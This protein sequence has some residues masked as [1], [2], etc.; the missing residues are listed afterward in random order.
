MA[1]TAIVDPAVHRTPGNRVVLH[2]DAVEQ[3]RDLA[4]GKAPVADGAG[5]AGGRRVVHAGDA[6]RDVLGVQRAARVDLFTRDHRDAGRRFTQG[7]PQAAAGAVAD[8]QVDRAVGGGVG[9]AGAVDGGGR[10]R[11]HGRFGGQGLGRAA[12]KRAEQQGVASGLFHVWNRGTGQAPGT[13]P[14]TGGARRI[15]R[16]VARV[17]VTA[18][19]RARKARGRNV[20]AAKAGRRGQMPPS[21]GSAAPT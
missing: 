16:Q 3:L 7:E 5:V 13:P 9:L 19:E 4:T 12:G 20:P 14:G 18:R 6:A 11:F 8:V 15:T 2:R 10:Q 21:G 17:G 1:S